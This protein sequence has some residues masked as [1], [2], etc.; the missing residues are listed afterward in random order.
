MALD[1]FRQKTETFLAWLMDIGVV[2]NP[3]VALVDLRLAGR[4]RGVMAQSDI[5]EDEVLF[6]VPRS[7][8]LN[9]ASE[10]GSVGLSTPPATLDMPS[11]LA[12]TAT[13]LAEDQRDH[14]KWGPYLAL[15]P[16]KLDSLVFWSESELL[17]LQASTVVSKIAKASAEELFYQYI[18]PLGLSQVN[19]ETCHRVASVI[20]AYAFDIPEKQ[21]SEENNNARE[22]DY[23]VSDDEEDETTILSM[24]PLADMLN[25]DAD[26]NNARLCCNNEDLEMRSIRPILKGEEIFN[27]YGQLPRSDLLR[28][29]G[30]VTKRYAPFDVA[31]ISTPFLLSVLATTQSLGTGPTLKLLSS[32]E[33]EQRITLAQ[34]EGVYEESYDLSHTGSDG[35]GISDELLALLYLLLVDD[36]NLLALEKSQALLPCR[37]KLATSLVGQVLAVV[38]QSRLQEYPTTIETDQMIL[39]A[40]NL[41]LRKQMAVQVRLGEKLVLEKAI[42]ESMSFTGDN[43]RMRLIDTRS[44]FGAESTKGKRKKADSG[45]AKKKGRLR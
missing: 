21:S 30:Y 33:V 36:E 34:R 5:D 41:P 4:G 11:W 2:I 37:S 39:Q 7:A 29:Y 3:K 23:L 18:S 38:L 25:A 19:I 15:L 9:T 40:G 24:I 16:Q 45:A 17:E 31:E 22:G 44:S 26:K 28:R 13:I 12:L 6:T 43:N 32:T 42:Q 35:P 27:D 20:M 8:V 1:D 14:S 10:L